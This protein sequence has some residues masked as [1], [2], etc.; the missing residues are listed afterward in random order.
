LR[1]DVVQTNGTRHYLYDG[2][3]AGRGVV[4]LDRY[5]APGPF[6]ADAARWAFGS[7]A[8]AGQLT[9]WRVIMRVLVGLLLV[10]SG[11][12][13]HGVPESD[14]KWLIVGHHSSLVP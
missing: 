5:C 8:G 12:L 7:A 1:L 6:K 13:D 10:A 4:G 14:G 11:A 3:L 2:S 9:R